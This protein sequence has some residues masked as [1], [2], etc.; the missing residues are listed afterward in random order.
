MQN[1]PLDVLACQLSHF[2]LLTGEPRS[3]EAPRESITHMG[4][5]TVKET[6]GKPVLA[7][8]NFRILLCSPSERWSIL[9]AGFLLP[10]H[11]CGWRCD[12]PTWKHALCAVD[13]EVCGFYLF[14]WFLFWDSILVG[15]QTGLKH[16]MVL[17]SFPL[18]C[19]EVKCVPS[20]LASLSLFSIL[21]FAVLGRDRTDP[22]PHACQQVL[23]PD[24]PALVCLFTYF[25]CPRQSHTA[26]QII[27]ETHDVAQAILE[28]TT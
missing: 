12:S 13:G 5:I 2:I 8:V 17:M 16:E 4:I 3:W 14:I 19:W 23:F 18:K 20:S 10:S 9:C 25:G 26:A 27:P 24:T 6:L 7:M 28:L 1:L 11:S 21:H 22:R 15:L